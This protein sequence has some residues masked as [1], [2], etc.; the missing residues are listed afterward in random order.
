MSMVKPGKSFDFSSSLTL[1][2]SLQFDIQSAATQGESSG[3]EDAKMTA[4]TM[5]AV[6]PQ[7]RR[8][9]VTL[10]SLLFSSC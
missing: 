6:K 3:G 1:R 7:T 2:H 5:M 9:E 10:R 8:D 4:K